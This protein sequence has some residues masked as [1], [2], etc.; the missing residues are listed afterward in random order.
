M[1][2]P[3]LTIVDLPYLELTGESFYLFLYSFFALAPLPET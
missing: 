2:A 1:L 3:L